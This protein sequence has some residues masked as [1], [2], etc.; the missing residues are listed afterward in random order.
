MINN[1]WLDEHYKEL[2]KRE[3]RYITQISKLQLENI[4]LKMENEKLKAMAEH[5]KSHSFLNIFKRLFFPKS[6]VE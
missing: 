1:D 2:E 6:M 5:S 3:Q 4:K